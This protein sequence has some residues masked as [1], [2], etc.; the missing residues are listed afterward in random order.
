MREELIL[1]LFFV[2]RKTTSTI[3]VDEYAMQ[4]AVHGSVVLAYLAPSAHPAI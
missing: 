1:F 4:M 2:F 3:I